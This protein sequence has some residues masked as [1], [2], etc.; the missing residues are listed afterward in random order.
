MNKYSK[1]LF[2]HNVARSSALDEYDAIAA[3]IEKKVKRGTRTK[4]IV[5][6]VL[7]YITGSCVFSNKEELI[8]DLYEARRI[9]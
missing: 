6:F 3:I 9:A 8:K 2:A 4:T 7:K 1:V 5:N